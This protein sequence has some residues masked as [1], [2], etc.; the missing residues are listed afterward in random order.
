MIDK[1][2]TLKEK[3]EGKNITDKVKESISDKI[4]VLESQKEVLK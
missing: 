4:K 1:I 2:K 3:L